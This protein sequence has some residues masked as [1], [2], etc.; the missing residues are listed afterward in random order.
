MKDISIDIYVLISSFDTKEFDTNPIKDSNKYY[1]FKPMPNISQIYRVRLREIKAILE[2]SLLSSSFSEE[3]TF[4]DLI[5][6][7][8]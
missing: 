2:D 4:Y 5:L 8:Q 3:M 6:D 7:Y 1:N